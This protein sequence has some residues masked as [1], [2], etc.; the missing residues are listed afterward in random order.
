[1]KPAIHPFIRL[2]SDALRHGRALAQLL[3]S[4]RRDAS[5]YEEMGFG[6]VVGGVASLLLA[7]GCI[8]ALFAVS[9]ATGCCAGAVIGLLLWSTSPELPEETLVRPAEPNCGTRGCAC[10]LRQVLRGTPRPAVTGARGHPGRRRRAGSR[11]SRR[12]CP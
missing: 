7:W 6:A 8:P 10:P 9:V 1:M 4:V 5:V 2:L 3:R 11:S 12:F